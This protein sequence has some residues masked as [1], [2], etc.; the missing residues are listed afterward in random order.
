ME[1][2]EYQ[3]ITSDLRSFFASDP[4]EF[5]FSTADWYFFVRKNDPYNPGYP[6][7]FFHPKRWD[8]RHSLSVVKSDISRAH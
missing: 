5:V 7:P 4:T 2:E 3:T 8:P 1:H 6:D